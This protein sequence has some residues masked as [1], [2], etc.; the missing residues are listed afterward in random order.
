MNA[1]DK[2]NLKN[3]DGKFICIGLDTDIDKLPACLKDAN[4]PVLEFNKAIIEKCSRYAAAYKLNFAFYER[5]GYEGIQTLQE[6]IAAIPDDI[7]I[8]ADAKRGDIGNTSLMYSEAILNNLNFDSLTVNPYMG[9]DSVAPFINNPEKLIF[10]LALTS[11]PGAAD[12]E[13]QKLENGLCLY[14]L[15]IEKVN[16]WNINRNCGIVFGATKHEELYENMTRIGELPVLLPGVGAQGG[17]LEDVLKTFKI[18]GRRHFL[19]NVSRGIIYKSSGNDFAFAALNEI[20]KLN[21]SARLLL[22]D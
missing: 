3:Q 4:N 5:G 2:L 12:F 15:V 21:E 11:N 1:F 17:S 13:K 22:N 6:T 9:Y 10:I 20:V 18:F 8:I 19:I 7:L 16:Q 14:Q